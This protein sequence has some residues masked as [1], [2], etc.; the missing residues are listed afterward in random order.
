MDENINV[1]LL[2]MTLQ[3]VSLAWHK[4]WKQAEM[5]HLALSAG[6]KN[7]LKLSNITYLCDIDLLI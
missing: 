7:P 3:L 5:T 2:N 1:C 6:K 4:D